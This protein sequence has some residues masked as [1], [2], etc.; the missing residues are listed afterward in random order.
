MPVT[1]GIL[2]SIL[3]QRVKHAQNLPVNI[4]STAR[5][6]LFGLLP[7]SR[8]REVTSLLPVFLEAAQLL[9]NSMN[10]KLVFV[11]PKAAAIDRKIFREA[12]LNNLNA[13]DVR[14]IE[15]DRY[16]VMGLM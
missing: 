15:D 3:S 14:L 6:K 5:L 12:G 9:Q 1:L 8:R 13:I 4:I 2:C 16:N 10:E 11:V 7:G